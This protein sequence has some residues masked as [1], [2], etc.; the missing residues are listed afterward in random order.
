[1]AAKKLLV[2]IGK[3]GAG[4]TTIIKKAFP[5]QEIIDVLPYVFAYK[6]NGRVPEEKTLDGYKD[7]YQALHNMSQAFVI[8][9]L[10]SNHPEFNVD[11]LVELQKKF[12]VTVFVCTADVDTLR[13][14]IIGRK[15]GDDMEAMERRL[16]WNTIDTYISLL[17][18][19]H[20]N[21]YVLNTN[22][23]II[24]NIKIVKE[25]IG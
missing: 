8:L 21:H 9:E 16:Q 2:F 11:Q 17:K 22:K 12:E 18:E 3:P 10:G 20:I 19:N 4:K 15:R 14:R 1:M 13:Q 6:V 25:L 7:M 24:E 23:E 5:D